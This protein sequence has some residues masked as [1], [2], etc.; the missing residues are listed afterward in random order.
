MLGRGPNESQ[1]GGLAGGGEIRIR[2]QSAASGMNGVRPSS[3]GCLKQA[4][5]GRTFPLPQ[6]HGFVGKARVQRF[7][8]GVRVHGHRL[9]A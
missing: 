8:I 5:W 4:L 2:G 1:A 6:R 7:F 3:P 9:D